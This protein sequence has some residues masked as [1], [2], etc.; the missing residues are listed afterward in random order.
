MFVAAVLCA[1]HA[2][3]VAWCRTHG[4]R[5]S[6]DGA[7]APSGRW[8]AV[9]VLAP[10]DLRGLDVDRVDYAVGFWRGARAA[11]VALDELARS[12]IRRRDGAGHGPAGPSPRGSG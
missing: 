11:T 12:R 9:R 4:Y 3:F 5:V 1:D 8:L 7:E 10:D 6:G 2:G